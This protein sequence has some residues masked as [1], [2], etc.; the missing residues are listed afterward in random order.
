MEAE[1]MTPKDVLK[2]LFDLLEDFAPSWYTEEHRIRAAN[3]LQESDDAQWHPGARNEEITPPAGDATH[4]KQ[5]RKPSR[6]ILTAI[7]S[8]KPVKPAGGPS[9]R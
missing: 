9:A 6:P 4:R 2:E 5:S 8:R 7:S 3:A 1:P